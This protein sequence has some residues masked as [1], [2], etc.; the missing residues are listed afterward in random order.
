MQ[1]Q[2]QANDGQRPNIGAKLPSPATPH[3][4]SNDY[5]YKVVAFFGTFAVNHA[6]HAV[7][8]HAVSR[9]ALVAQNEG[10]DGFETGS[11]RWTGESG[12]SGALFG[13]CFP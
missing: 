12:K 13:R 10:C 8:L 3:F 7:N 6:A 4:S 9:K 5:G 11:W 1:G 2:W